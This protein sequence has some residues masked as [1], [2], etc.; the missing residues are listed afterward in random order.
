MDGATMD[1]RLRTVHIEAHPSDA[2]RIKALHFRISDAQTVSITPIQFQRLRPIIAAQNGIEIPAEDA[3]PEIIDAE[4]TIAEQQGKG[5]DFSLN[6]VVCG[7]AALTNAEEDDIYE[8]PL[9][10]LNRRAESL[11]RVLDYLV[12]GIGQCS[13]M[14]K[15]KGGNPVPNPWYARKRGF[16]GAIVPLD[17]FAGGA[18]SAA[19]ERPSGDVPT[20]F[21]ALSREP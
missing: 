7:V 5:L 16:S 18:A 15:W 4:R 6:S 12:C 8:W 2:R 17:S 9:L 11:S 1:A 13:G 14:V 3:N 10:K 21:A 20:Q 19:V